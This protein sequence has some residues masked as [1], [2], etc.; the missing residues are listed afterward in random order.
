[1]DFD[2]EGAGSI[3]FE[4]FIHLLTPRLIPNDTHENINRIFTLFDTEKTGFISVKD[5]H[6]VAH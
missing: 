2:A 3:T 1:L 5:L 6:R 4:Q